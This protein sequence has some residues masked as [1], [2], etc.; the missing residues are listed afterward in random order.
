MLEADV[1]ATASVG[2]G[3]GAPETMKKKR[4]A[5]K[6]EMIEKEAIVK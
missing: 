3:V 4:R 1:V 2:T 6:M 5:N